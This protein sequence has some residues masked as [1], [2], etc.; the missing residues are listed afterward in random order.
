MI[1]YLLQSGQP[2]GTA[3]TYIYTLLSTITKD[4]LNAAQL[5]EPQDAAG[6]SRQL[7]G[8]Q[9]VCGRPDRFPAA[10]PSMS[11]SFR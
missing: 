8:P 9:C 11:L 2:A 7:T 4:N 3:S 5:L 1:K 6:D 10:R